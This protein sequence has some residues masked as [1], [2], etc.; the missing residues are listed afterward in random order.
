MN[1]SSWDA[2]LARSTSV[3]YLLG[4]SY[5]VFNK[6]GRELALDNPS[7]GEETI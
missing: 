7:D 6:Q 1:E 2:C 5:G 4:T 3:A